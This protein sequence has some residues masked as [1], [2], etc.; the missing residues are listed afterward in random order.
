VNFGGVRQPC[1]LS[2]V[3]RAAF[4][5]VGFAVRLFVRGGSRFDCDA[6]LVDALPRN[7]GDA[8]LGHPNCH[9]NEHGTAR[10]DVPGGAGAFDIGAIIPVPLVFGQNT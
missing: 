1:F 5:C 7:G 8:A 9:R 10:M 4:R 6:C 3:V 2:T